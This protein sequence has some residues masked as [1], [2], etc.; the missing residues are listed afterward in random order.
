MGDD[1][2]PL[3]TYLTKPYSSRDLS[4]T[5][6][7]FNYRLS[8]ARRVS[9]NAFGI[10]ANRFRI[11]LTN[12]Y[13]TPD[14]VVEMIRAIAALHNYLR[15]EGGHHYLGQG[16]VDM[17]DVNHHVVEGEWRRHSNN[18]ESLQPTRERNPT[19]EAKENRDELA[20]YF[21]HG[22][23]QVPWQDQMINP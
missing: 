4:R 2:F 20:D 3:T 21:A 15:K 16:Y 1:A 17:E 7:I 14:R 10:M 22:G 12:I 13:Q 11:L 19:T 18:L 6:R 9:E 5:K 8:R 23:G